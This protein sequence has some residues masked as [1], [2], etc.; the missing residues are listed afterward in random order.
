LGV[1]VWWWLFLVAVPAA[2]RAEQ[3]SAVDQNTEP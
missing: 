3:E 2:Y 1:L